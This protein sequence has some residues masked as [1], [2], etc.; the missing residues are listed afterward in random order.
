MLKAEKRFPFRKGWDQV[1]G[2]KQPAIKAGIMTGLGIKTRAAWL[3][4]L[5]G[6]VEP[7]VSEAQ[8]LERLFRK[9]GITDIWGVGKKKVRI[10]RKQTNA[11]H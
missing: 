5:D 1:P 2:G 6:A 7:T 3:K 8:F 11:A 10:S 9:H 4:R